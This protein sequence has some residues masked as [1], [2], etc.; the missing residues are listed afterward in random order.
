[1]TL[2]EKFGIEILQENEER[3][4]YLFNMKESVAPPKVVNVD[5]DADQTELV[6]VSA[7]LL[8]FVSQDALVELW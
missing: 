8:Y 1:M 4:G 2:E 5:N 6:D 3:I 7:L